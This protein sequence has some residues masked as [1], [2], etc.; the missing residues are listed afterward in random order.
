M[1][2]LETQQLKGEIA[3]LKEETS[4]IILS[5]YYQV[6]DVQ[7]VGDFLGD[8]LG[9]SRKAAEI[10]DAKHIIFAAVDFMAEVA[11]ILNPTK[12]VLLPDIAAS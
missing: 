3:A 9:L 8:S 2:I 6:L 10:Q 4:T 12:M 7:D 5:H 1:S 11:K